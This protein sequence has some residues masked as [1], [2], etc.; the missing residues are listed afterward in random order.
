M[1]KFLN[2]FIRKQSHNKARIES[3]SNLD[4]KTSLGLRTKDLK[5]KKEEQ[6]LFI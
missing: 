2:F 3:N 6:H 4:S 5:D 1:F